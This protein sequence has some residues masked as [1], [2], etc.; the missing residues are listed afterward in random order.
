V[1]SQQ[2]YGREPNKQRPIWAENNCGEYNNHVKIGDE[3][4]C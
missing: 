4:I 2:A 1:D 3:D